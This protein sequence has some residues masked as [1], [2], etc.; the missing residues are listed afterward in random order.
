MPFGRLALD[1][2]SPSCAIGP[3][4]PL[5]DVDPVA[6]ASS[7]STFAK[8]LMTC[9]TSDIAFACSMLTVPSF[10]PLSAANG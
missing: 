9:A 2:S 10:K 4:Q 1:C 8:L 3:R 6:F 7:T 5:L